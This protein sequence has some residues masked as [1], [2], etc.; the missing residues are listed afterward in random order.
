MS[1]VL[2]TQ[3]KLDTLAQ[4]INTKT[5]AT[6]PLT[7]DD[8]NSAIRGMFSGGFTPT[9]EIEIS[10]N[11]N[12]NVANYAT[13]NVAIPFN[14][15]CFNKNSI[16]P[17]E[18][19]VYIDIASQEVVAT[20]T[21]SMSF[22]PNGY[23]D[24]YQWTDATTQNISSFYADTSSTSYGR[25]SMKTGAGSETYGYFTFDLS[26]KPSENYYLTSVSCKI[27]LSNTA[28]SNER[29]EAWVAL[30]LNKEVISATKT[31]LTGT[32]KVTLILPTATLMS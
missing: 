19:D 30:C 12:Y 27:A 10:E 1:Q 21:Q 31:N 14:K 28:T 5:G 26:N 20:S 16:M 4:T 17:K 2:I 9:G 11:G 22:I 13:A 23:L 32:S 25:I 3:S 15:I 18:G 7:L 6:L 8:M 29:S 24:D